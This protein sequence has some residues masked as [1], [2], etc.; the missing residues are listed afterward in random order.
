MQAICAAVRRKVHIISM[1]W[2]IDP[3]DD[4]ND[5]RDLEGAILEAAKEDILMFCSAKDKGAK[6]TSSFPS[7]ATN[8]IFKIGAAEASGAP[9][10]WVGD[11]TRIDFTFPGNQVELEGLGNDINKEVVSGS[12]VATALA[13][14]LAA[15]ILYCVQVRVRLTQ[16]RERENAKREFQ[17]LKKH[18]HMMKAFKN[19][20]TTEESKN[21]YIAV[22]ELFGKLVR[23]SEKCDKPEW[24]DLIVKA[25]TELCVKL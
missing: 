16:G 24:I 15:L 1:S 5:K 21:K 9:D 10:A 23:E 13:A 7:L 22:W 8:K 18:D 12:S 4:E 17:A 2:T 3:P 11:L 6:Q 25:G 14:G 19:I 20:G